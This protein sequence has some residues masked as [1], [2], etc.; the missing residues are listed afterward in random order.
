M[1]KNIKCLIIILM[2]ILLF[3]ISI[4]TKTKVINNIIRQA[5]F[6]ALEHNQNIVEIKFE[7]DELYNAIKSQINRYIN[8]S[9]DANKKIY[10]SNSNLANVKELQ[11]KDKGI[12][13]TAG[14]EKFTSLE[15]LNI[16]NNMIDGLTN[17]SKI[18][19]LKNLKI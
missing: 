17:I 8:S 9:D 2:S 15:T 16:S 4:N 10:I 6:G 11:L 18:T 14:L 5:Y 19:S 1:R 12:T 13:K 3:F 7:D